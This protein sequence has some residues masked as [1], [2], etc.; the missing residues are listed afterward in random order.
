MFLFE[1]LSSMHASESV[2][3]LSGTKTKTTTSYLY[4][5]NTNKSSIVCNFPFYFIIFR[6]IICS[7]LKKH[8][9]DSIILYIFCGVKVQCIV[10]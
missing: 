2:N 5:L 10:L 3:V 1:V 4:L 9:T 7:H 8:K 6:I